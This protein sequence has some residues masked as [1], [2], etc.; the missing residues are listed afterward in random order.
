MLPL[1]HFQ[2][3]TGRVDIGLVGVRRLR[4][5]R[6]RVSI[7]GYVSVRL[8][9]YGDLIGRVPQARVHTGEGRVPEA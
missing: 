4:V 5:L 1:V 7:V 9:Y 3:P 2:F 8:F 6:C